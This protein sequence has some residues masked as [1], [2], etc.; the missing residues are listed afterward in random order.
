MRRII[1]ISLVVFSFGSL[2]AQNASIRLKIT[3]IKNNDGV[4]RIGIYNSEQ[5]FLEEKKVAGGAVIEKLKQ[6]VSY[7]FDSLPSGNYA[8]AV[9][10]DE[11]NNQKLDT[12]ILGMPV[13]NYGFSNNKFG[14][15][16]PPGFDEVAVTLKPGKIVEL[17]INL[18]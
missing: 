18:E 14:T 1:I 7:V 2:A 12:N 5:S 15:F 9:W 3:G 8:I 16:G 10:H 17:T 11:N 6:Q 13:E 4:V